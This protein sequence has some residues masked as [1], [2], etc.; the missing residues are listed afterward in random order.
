MDIPRKSAARNRKIRRVIYGAVALIAVAA[1]T[2]G[3]MRLKP[4]PP[5][6]EAGQLWPD[7]VK[8]G[9]MIRNVHGL[10]T[11]VPEEIR[12]IPATS[13]GRVE[14]RLAQ[15]GAPVSPDTV[16]LELSNPEL[17]QSMMESDSQ[18]KSAEAAYENRK[19]E[20]ES[21]ILNQKASAATVA[22]DYSQAKLTAESNESLYKQGLL[23]DLQLKLSKTKA[24]E[25]AA[26]NDLEIKRL[27]INTVAVRTQLAVQQA[28]LDQ[29][30]ALAQ[31]RRQQVDQLKVRAGI[32]GVLQEMLVQVGQQVTPG[33]NLCRV[34]DPKKLKAEIKV[35]ETQ[36]KDIL[37]GQSVEVD[38]RN[39]VIGGSV[40][41]IDPAVI[42][43]TRTVDVR[44]EGE[45]PKGAVP[46]LSVDG[47]IELEKMNDV[48][49]VGRPA[50][51]QER[52]TIS[53]FKIDPD[54]KTAVRTQ[55]KLGRM[56]VTSVEILEG[57]KVGDRVILSDTSQWD[58]TDRIRLN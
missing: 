3:V 58:N 51:G 24:E 50:F 15:A 48:L 43:G 31:L 44:L 14:R 29:A 17:Q 32:S 57:L 46:D 42:N 13:Q 19:V 37:I 16:L 26:R 35:A 7:T 30:K 20:L 9:Q 1:I 56:S 10:G 49:Y 2:M 54:G 40:M 25:L 34:A 38:T 4:A 23:P 41:R 12:W 18:L 11:L 36:A 21:T 45:L 6:V 52:A 8:R 28:L 33:T 55:V 53:L 39:G 27:E 47:T 22:S 5:S